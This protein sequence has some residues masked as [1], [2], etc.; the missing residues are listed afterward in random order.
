MD[1]PVYLRKVRDEGEG[2]Y[3]WVTPAGAEGD[4]PRPGLGGLDEAAAACAGRRVVLLLPGEV[5]LLTHATVP[6]RNR[7]RMM[8][9]LPYLLEERLA[10][11]VEVMHFAAG[12]RQRDGTVEVAVIERARL[13]DELGALREAGIDPDHALPDLLALPLEP[14]AWTVL[15]DGDMALVRTGLRSGF[16]IDLVTLAPVLAAALAE[17]GDE[18]EGSRPQRLLLHTARNSTLERDALEALGPELVTTASDAAPIEFLAAHA[19]RDPAIELLRGDFSRRER[20][21]RTFRPW[22]PV[23]ITLGVLLLVHTAILA[24]DYMRLDRESTTLRAEVNRTFTETFPGQRIVD[25]RLQMERS[26]QALRG[27]GGGGG[28]GFLDVLAAAAPALQEVEGAVLQRLAWR[29]GQLDVALAIG[30]VQA[31][32]RLVQRIQSTGG[33]TA[34]IQS[35]STSNGRV[36]ARLQLRAAP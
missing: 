1:D 32:D 10:Q 9:A 35:A 33:V 30:D 6:A 12:P 29:G 16:A 5:V 4:P 3:E 15:E 34:E 23:A 36:E 7:Q 24:W 11:D 14:G 25:P 21:G 2:V 22:L 13:E 19:G 20:F 8:Q 26:L 28:S 18:E 17:T 31:L 27:G